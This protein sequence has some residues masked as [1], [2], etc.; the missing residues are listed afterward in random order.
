MIRA[1]NLIQ[2]AGIYAL[3]VRS[4]MSSWI[5]LKHQIINKGLLNVLFRGLVL[6]ILLGGSGGALKKA[7]AWNYID[8]EINYCNYTGGNQSGA[9]NYFNAADWDTIIQCA[10][11]Y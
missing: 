9:W 2:Q 7:Y 3:M 8:N 4:K 10:L 11:S 1:W 5:K 6:G